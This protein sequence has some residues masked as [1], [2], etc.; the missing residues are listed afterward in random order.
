M[1][2][3]KKEPGE[4]RT[5][6]VLPGG[7][8]RK[9]RRKKKPVV[10]ELD[11]EQ[12]AQVVKDTIAIVRTKYPSGIA[13]EKEQRMGVRVFITKPATLHL[14]YERTFHLGGH[15][16]AK[17]SVGIFEPHYAEER[18][19]AFESA[20]KFLEAKMKAEAIGLDK[21]IKERDAKLKGGDKLDGDDVSPA[22]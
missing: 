21:Y 22:Q 2:T 13:D 16:Y 7:D 1:G 4:N 9:P 12:S 17:I 6:I 8:K 14:E 3:E 19:A 15:S 10:P 11:D 18:E 20:Q 5:P